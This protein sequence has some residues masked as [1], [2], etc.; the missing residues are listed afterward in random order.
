[1]F[2]FFFLFFPFFFFFDLNVPKKT[3]Q[4][5]LSS[6]VRGEIHP[7]HKTFQLSTT[8][9]PAALV[10]TYFV[11]YFPD[12]SVLKYRDTDTRVLDF[13]VLTHTNGIPMTS[14]L[15]AIQNR[16]TTAFN[17][18]LLRCMESDDAYDSIAAKVDA[19]ILTT[20][21]PSSATS[22]Q[23]AALPPT[24]VSDVV[25]TPSTI[26]G[27][28]ATTATTTTTTT[29]TTPATAVAATPLIQSQP[30]S[31][32]YWRGLLHINQNFPVS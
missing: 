30:P 9:P 11:H 2:G 27:T 32:G 5:I 25:S 19:A 13:I 29:T 26:S 16:I 7:P 14:A 6:G 22:V 18:I 17:F 31:H 8:T 10:A 4:V 12:L 20:P 28:T 3:Q 21:L 23:Q 24:T 1:M 15:P